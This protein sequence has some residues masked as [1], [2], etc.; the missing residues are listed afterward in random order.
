VRRFNVIATVVI[1][2]ILQSAATYAD[3]EDGSNWG[4]IT[5]FYVDAR[6]S[7]MRLDFSRAI[8]NPGNCEGADFYVRE[9]DDSAA[10][11]RF[12]RVVL[13]AHLANRKAKF[14]INGCTTAK[15]WGKTRP[16]IT[17]IYIGS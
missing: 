15:W 16:H 4:T 1:A 2:G 13:A 5:E 10:S 12:L 6:G 8:V 14:W 11:D 3:G 9:L 17:D 7:V